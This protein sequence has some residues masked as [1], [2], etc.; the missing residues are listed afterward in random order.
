MD[1]FGFNNLTEIIMATLMKGGGL[2]KEDVTKK[3]CFGVDG[4]FVSRGVK[5]ESQ[6]KF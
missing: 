3:L 1:W 2:I 5:H 4:A 6:R